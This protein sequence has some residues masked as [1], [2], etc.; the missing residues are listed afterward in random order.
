MRDGPPANESLFDEQLNRLAIA[1]EEGSVI[2]LDVDEF[3][4]MSPA[5]IVSHLE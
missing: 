3:R 4:E 1:E 2:V 5:P